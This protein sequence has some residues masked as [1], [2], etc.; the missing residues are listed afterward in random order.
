MHAHQWMRTEN[1]CLKNEFSD[2]EYG[3]LLS[4]KIS[5]RNKIYFKLWRFLEF[6]V[7]GKDAI[8]AGKPY[9]FFATVFLVLFLS[10]L[11][12]VQSFGFERIIA[13]WAH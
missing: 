11:Y 12:F 10:L 5:N 1:L 13:L 6:E 7:S 2:P 9:M 3:G 4:M 8:Y